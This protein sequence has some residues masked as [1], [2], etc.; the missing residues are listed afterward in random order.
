MEVRPHARAGPCRES[1][2]STPRP[3]GKA[4]AA[5]VRRARRARTWPWQAATDRRARPGWN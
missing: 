1:S 5:A 4:R 2:D 3:T